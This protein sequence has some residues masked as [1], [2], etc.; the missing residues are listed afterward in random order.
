M[1]ILKRTS[2]APLVDEY[3]SY[4]TAVEAREFRRLVEASFARAGHD[5][6]VHVDHVADRRGTTFGLWNIGAFC[7]GADQSQ[8]AELID[9]HV[10]RV[11]TPP[12]GMGELTPNELKSSLY[13][14][15]VDDR[16][17]PDVDSLGYARQVAPGLLELLAVDLPDSVV[18]LRRSDFA[19]LGTLSELLLR[20]RSALRE[21]LEDGGVA[22]RTV[23]DA[24]GAFTVLTG[25]S[26]FTASLALILSETLDHFTGEA[27]RGYGVLVAV[28]DRHQLLYR[29]IDDPSA[30]AALGD[31]FEIA[32]WAYDQSSGPLSPNVY[33]VRD[34]RWS[35][36]TSVDEGKP[37]VWLRGELAGMIKHSA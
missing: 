2:R 25:P 26:F 1:R 6:T 33:W 29:V 21:L 9:E 23:T 28:P 14:R 10:Q 12:R 24:R 13:L 22:A 20:G 5:V 30:A 34:L 31:M 32:R 15:L 36:V 4:F 18:P 11:T 17:V 8:W 7:R 3:L 37:R 27:D 16:S 35:Q 19:A